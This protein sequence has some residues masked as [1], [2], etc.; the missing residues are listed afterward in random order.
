MS[1]ERMRYKIN[2]QSYG[3]VRY[4]RNTYKYISTWL[5]I[6]SYTTFYI[7]SKVVLEGYIHVHVFRCYT[8]ILSYINFITFHNHFELV[9]Y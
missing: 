8:N 3:I 4:N 2:S 7:L 5:Q 1:Q 6:V 9:V